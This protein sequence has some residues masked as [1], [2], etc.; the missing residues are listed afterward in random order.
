[1]GSIHDDKDHA[2]GFGGLK[3]VVSIDSRAFVRVRG[4]KEAVKPL[5]A[6]YSKWESATPKQKLFQASYT[7]MWTLECSENDVKWNNSL[8]KY[9]QDLAKA[10]TTAVFYCDERDLVFN[11]QVHSV[12][13]VNVKVISVEVS[14]EDIGGK[15]LRRF[16]VELQY[17]P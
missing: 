5:T 4:F 8:A 10:G 1:L 16:T 3:V 17:A 13:S 6:Q 14:Y 7:T 15:N 11:G 2:D 12:T 9:L